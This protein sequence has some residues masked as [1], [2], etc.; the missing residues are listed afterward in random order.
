M[1]FARRSWTALGRRAAPLRA[2]TASSAPAHTQLRFIRTT[3]P[4]SAVPLPITAHGPPPKAPLPTPTEVSDFRRRQREASLTNGDPNSVDS[5]LSPAT[6]PSSTGTATPAPTTGTKPRKPLPS[7]FYKQAHVLPHP[8]TG[9]FHPHLDS[10]PLKTPHKNPLILP[11]NKPHLAHLVA[12]EYNSLTTTAQAS[13]GYLLPITQLSSRCIDYLSDK[14]PK[15]QH[16]QHVAMVDMCLKYLDTDTLLCLVPPPNMWMV[17]ESDEPDELTLRKL[18][19]KVLRETEDWIERHLFP[20][21]VFRELD[22]AKGFLATA[23]QLEETRGRIRAWLEGLDVWTLVGIERCT[24]SAKS[25]L[26]ALRLVG[27]WKPELWVSEARKEGGGSGIDAETEGVYDESILPNNEPSLKNKGT[28]TSLLK[29]ARTPSH[30]PPPSDE[31]ETL[32]STAPT[33]GESMDPVLGGLSAGDPAQNKGTNTALPTKPTTTTTE[34][35]DASKSPPETTANKI[36]G[37]EEAAAAAS[38]ETDWQTRQWGEVED[39][40][41]VLN[42]DVRRGLGAGWCVAIEM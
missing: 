34:K 2:P 26:V 6:T 15:S 33:P 39:S 25:L 7:R 1:M 5:T 12:A 17:S 42:E 16:T 10:R 18:Q 13:K 20:G 29:P 9:G 11:P 31:V 37:I 28:N 30:T 38:L 3:R 4:S 40:H 36:W 32:D 23:P 22:T 24:I 41:D 14:D 27:G 35:Q 19:V 21:I 8:A